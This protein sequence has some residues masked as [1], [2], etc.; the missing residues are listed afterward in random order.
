MSSK[1]LMLVLC[2]MCVKVLSGLSK[3]QLKNLMMYHSLAKHYALAE[4][5]GL[6]QS[7]P[8]T[9]LA[10]GK[11]T[12]N[13]TNDAGIVH[14]R[15]RWASA[16]IF[17]SVSATAPMAVYELDRVLLPDALFRAQPPVAA[18]PPVPTPAPSEGYGASVPDAHAA[19]ASDGVTSAPDRKA[20][21]ADADSSAC[22]AGARFASYAAAAAFGAMTLGAL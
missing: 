17:G 20:G 14:V 9:T 2:L 7:N 4:F 11:Y 22:R 5:D 12:V 1:S 18:T 15:S 8:V 19:S 3:D 10:G 21:E 13:V 16:K 6:S